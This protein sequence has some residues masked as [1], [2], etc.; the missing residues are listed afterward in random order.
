MKNAISTLITTT[1]AS[2]VGTMVGT[3]FGLVIMYRLVESWSENA[4][5]EWK[6]KHKVAF[7]KYEEFHKE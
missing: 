6:E 1:G 3:V 7:T 5:D 4:A 2:I